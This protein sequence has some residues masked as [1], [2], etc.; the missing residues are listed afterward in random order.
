MQPS[1]SKINIQ[2]IKQRENIIDICKRISVLE[3]FLSSSL[4]IFTCIVRPMDVSN[5]V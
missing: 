1:G 3:R 5:G 4:T 2:G